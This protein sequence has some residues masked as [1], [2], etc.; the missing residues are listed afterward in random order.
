MGFTRVT[1]CYL[2]MNGHSIGAQ[3]LRFGVSPTDTLHDR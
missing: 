1:N 2:P 3:L